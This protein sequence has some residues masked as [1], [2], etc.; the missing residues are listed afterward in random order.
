MARSLKLILCVLIA[1]A[2]IQSYLP[3]A[4]S[5]EAAKEPVLTV[6]TGEIG[7]IDLEKS[8]LVVKQL[9]D[10]KAQTYD[11]VTISIAAA[12]AIDKDGTKAGLSELKAGDKV[13]VEYTANAEG[14]NVATSILVSK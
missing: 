11:N 10:E 7:A 9:K 2:M 12:T 5:Q 4:F 1:T 13:S 6:A 8:I 14:V 3:K